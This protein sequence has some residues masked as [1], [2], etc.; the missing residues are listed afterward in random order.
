MGFHGIVNHFDQLQ[1]AAEILFFILLDPSHAALPGAIFCSQY[2][3]HEC[4]LI[5]C[6]PHHGAWR[7]PFVRRLA[8]NFAYIYIYCIKHSITKS[9][10]VSPFLLT[11]FHFSNL[12]TKS[13]L[14]RQQ[15]WHVPDRTHIIFL[16]TQ[17]SH[18]IR[19][20]F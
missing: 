11:F 1:A 10:T 19:K 20:R 3:N 2:P 4:F 7:T 14:L 18:L 12:N 15:S 5:V 9:I 17:R 16:G 13:L 8:Y 6:F